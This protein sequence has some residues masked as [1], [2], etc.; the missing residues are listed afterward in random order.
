MRQFGKLLFTL[1]CFSILSLIGGTVA[2]AIEPEGSTEYEGLDVSR[3]QE[4][5]DFKAVAN[6]GVEIV[7]IKASEGTEWIDP[8]FEKNYEG[9]KAA[10]LKVGFY[11]YIIARSVSDAINEANFFVSVIEDKPFDTKLAVDFE[12]FGELTKEEINQI[13]LAFAEEVEN[14]TGKEVVIYSNS[15]N[16][17]NIF[18]ESLTKYS[19]WVAQYDGNEISNEVIWDTWAGWQYTDTGTIEGVNGNADLNI[20]NEGIFLKDSSQ[21]EEPDTTEPTSTEPS[22]TNTTTYI[23]KKGDTLYHIARSFDVTVASIVE[24]NN[25]NNPNLIYPGDELRI[26]IDNSSQTY[27]IKSGDTLWKIAQEH[28]TTVDRLASVN[29][30]K[31]PNLI[32]P[33]VTLKI[34]K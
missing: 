1:F 8:Y 32:Y 10:G 25:I 28:G 15:N 11:H 27:V 16:A 2:Y 4:E 20:F 26:F 31:N 23:V 17:S 19:L 22:D 21:V 7:Y 5:V 14:L 34:N 33:G 3:H 6:A 29:N 12:D 24:E 13:T 18:D 30:I 9:A